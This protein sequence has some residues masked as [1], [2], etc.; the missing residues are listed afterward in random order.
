[1]TST[2]VSAL[3][4][5]VDLG[6]T[7]V[8]AALVDSAGTVL[9]G[10]RARRPTGAALSSDGLADA[11]R[12]V[13]TEAVGALPAGT[14]LL[15]V[16]IGCA[17]PISALGGFVSPLNLPV[18][19]GYPLADLAS[20]I[21]PEVPV[22]V[23]MDG[24]CIALAEQWVG[25]TRGYDNSLGMIVSTGIGGGIVLHGATVSGSTGNAG[26]IGHIEVAGFD[27]PCAC[28]GIGCV[29]AIASGPKTVAWARAQGWSGHSGEE[30]GASHRAGDAVAVAA[31]ERSG[32]AIGQAIASAAALLDLDVVAIGGGFSHVSPDLF[33]HVRQAISRRRQFDFV[34]KVKV[35]P[36]ALSGD[37][38]LIG[39]AALV[40]RA[41]SVG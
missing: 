31:I 16:G 17:G 21:V 34:T 7:K 35:V 24:L 2:A 12:A 5:A 29:E 8:E 13:M 36:S 33:D 18:W 41:D 14:T 23:R 20:S 28:G 15:G 40:H 10:S 37:G 22:T 4:L 1:M 39:A 38:P 25:A 3:A 6:G 30:L 32:R 26:H 9:P 11:V 19:R 27:D